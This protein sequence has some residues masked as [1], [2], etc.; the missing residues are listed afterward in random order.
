MIGVRFDGQTGI[1]ELVWEVEQWRVTCEM[2]RATSGRF[3]I[4]AMRI[5]PLGALSEEGLTID[6]LKAIRL[7]PARAYARLNSPGTFSGAR[8]TQNSRG[9]PRTLN[10]RFYREVWE[11]YMALV[12]SGTKAPAKTLA[13]E[14]D[15]SRTAMRSVLARC[16][17]MPEL[18]RS[19][20]TVSRKGSHGKTTRTR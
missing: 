5:D 19:D 17:K 15:Y 13:E 7:G 12:Q 2:N 9:R 8:A 11:R 16:K 20:V 14:Y 10:L 6:V 3:V 4:G 1:A 18:Q